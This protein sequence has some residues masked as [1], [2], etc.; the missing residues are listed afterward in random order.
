MHWQEIGERPEFP[1][2]GNDSVHSL[3]FA[4]GY[5]VLK[6]RVGPIR[7]KSAIHPLYANYWFWGKN[8]EFDNIIKTRYG[9]KCP[10]R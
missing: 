2:R 1:G 6:F 5:S 4:K 7:H 9:P 3:E 10:S 8:A